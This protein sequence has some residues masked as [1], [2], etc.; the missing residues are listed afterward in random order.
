MQRSRKGRKI[1][2]RAICLGNR[3]SYRS[4]KTLGNFDRLAYGGFPATCENDADVKGASRKSPQ[5]IQRLTKSFLNRDGTLDLV[6]ASSTWVRACA[7]ALGCISNAR[8]RR[9]KVAAL[10]G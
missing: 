9:D 1:S 2:P 6:S 4:R 8:I 5:T 10:N 3:F 7:A